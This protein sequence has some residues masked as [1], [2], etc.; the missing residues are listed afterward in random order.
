MTLL[1][2]MQFERENKEEKSLI[3]NRK[4]DRGYCPE[5]FAGM[6]KGILNLSQSNRDMVLTN[7]R[8]SAAIY[9]HHS[10][11]FNI[12]LPVYTS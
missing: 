7:P 11:N 12:T 1:T 3:L 10:I 5:G 4:S 2:E 9:W 6:Y 8:S